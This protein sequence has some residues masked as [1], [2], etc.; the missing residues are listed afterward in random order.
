MCFLLSQWCYLLGIRTPHLLCSPEQ[1][2]FPSEHHSDEKQKEGVSSL[3]LTFPEALGSRE[4]EAVLRL[5]YGCIQAA[6]CMYG[7]RTEGDGLLGVGL[8]AG[9]RRS[10]MGLVSS[11][12]GLLLSAA[13]FPG[14]SAKLQVTLGL[15]PL[16]WEKVS[17]DSSGVNNFREMCSLQG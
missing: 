12:P 3:V 16:G 2:A 5:L 1:K 7:G 13:R 9:D 11:D 4:Q 15:P 8:G 6:V 17:K 14:A 10:A